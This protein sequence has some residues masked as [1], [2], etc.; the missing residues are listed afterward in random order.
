MSVQIKT[1]LSTPALRFALYEPVEFINHFL[2]DKLEWKQ[3]RDPHL[4]NLCLSHF[5]LV[6]VSSDLRA[7][8]QLAASHR[9]HQ[10]ECLAKRS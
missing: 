1:S 5:L 7:S 3:V 6:P 2:V 10:H 4:H 9:L 8:H